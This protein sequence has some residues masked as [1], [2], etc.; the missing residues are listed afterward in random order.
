MEVNDTTF[1]TRLVAPDAMMGD[2]EA[3]LPALQAVRN[4]IRN[5][6]S[7]LLDMGVRY[8]M[9]HEETKKFLDDTYSAVHAQILKESGKGDDSWLLYGGIRWEN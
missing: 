6:Y 2:A 8:G 9:T 3:G 1:G 4:A 7:T 5:D